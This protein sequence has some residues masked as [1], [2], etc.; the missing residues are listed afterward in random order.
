MDFNLFGIR[1]YGIVKNFSSLYSTLL[2][3]RILKMAPYCDHE[4]L[5]S[6]NRILY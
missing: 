2:Q 6:A 4:K 3:T 5:H 1:K